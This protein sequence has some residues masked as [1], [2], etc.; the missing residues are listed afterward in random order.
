MKAVAVADRLQNERYL[1]AHYSCPNRDRSILAKRWV[2]DSNCSDVAQRQ[3][4][5]QQDMSDQ[6]LQKDLE[7][8]WL[9]ASKSND[10]HPTAKNPVTGS[11]HRPSFGSMTTNARRCKN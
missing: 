1:A 2:M 3:G 8:A 5:Q 6:D 10:S 9:Q 11:V 7:P 4:P